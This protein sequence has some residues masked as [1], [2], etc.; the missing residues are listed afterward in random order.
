MR[1]KILKHLAG[2]CLLLKDIAPAIAERPENVHRVMR[3]MLLADILTQ[4]GNGFY[5][6]NSKG[7]AKWR[8]GEA[9]KKKEVKP[10]TIWP[11]GFMGNNDHRPVE[12]VLDIQAEQ[13]ASKRKASKRPIDII[14]T[15]E[16]VDMAGEGTKEISSHER[17]MQSITNE[18]D[19]LENKISK[20]EV[21]L[22]PLPNAVAKIA[23]AR[24]L[25][26]LVINGEA[27]Q[28]EMTEFVDWAERVQ[29]I[30]KDAD[31]G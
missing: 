24:R 1:E 15:P 21:T 4:S 7:L 13:Q 9:K 25:F 31:G 3:N 17:S 19:Q 20:P 11:K 23:I 10:P 29:E 8:A 12:D 28:L 30:M 26:G 16:E 14:T 18:L 22:P 27:F 2:K 5:Q 6:I